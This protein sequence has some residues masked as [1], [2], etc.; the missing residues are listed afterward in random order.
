MWHRDTCNRTTLLG[1]KL[2]S[3]LCDLLLRGDEGGIPLK[4]ETSPRFEESSLCW[5]FFLCHR[6]CLAL[7]YYCPLFWTSSQHSYELCSHS[8]LVVAT[9]DRDI[10]LPSLDIWSIVLEDSAISELH[11]CLIH[12]LSLVSDKL[13]AFCITWVERVDIT[14]LPLCS[15]GIQHQWLCRPSTFIYNIILLLF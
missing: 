1:G 15:V 5:V 9:P 7:H 12:N 10:E 4:F 2:S 13:E 3:R 11:H 6:Y 14:S 8:D